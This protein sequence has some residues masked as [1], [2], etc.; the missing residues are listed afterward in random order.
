MPRL[1]AVWRRDR[2]L[3]LRLTSAH[4]NQQSKDVKGF[5]ELQSLQ[6]YPKM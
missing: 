3:D 4:L 1:S 2:G 6:E 5:V